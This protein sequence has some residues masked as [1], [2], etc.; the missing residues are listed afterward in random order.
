MFV[1]I[2]F[3]IFLGMVVACYFCVHSKWRAGVLLAASYLFCGFISLRALF[4][5]LIISAVTYLAGREIEK[6]GSRDK[7]GMGKVLL[8]LTIGS[9]LLL[10]GAYKYISYGFLRL[11]ILERMPES[12]LAQLVMPV[13]LSFYLFQAIGYLTDIYRKKHKAEKNFIYL[14]LYLAFFAKFVSGPIE[15]EEDFIP[16]LKGLEKVRFFHRGRL[17]TAF[18][19]MLWGYFMKMVVADRLAVTADKIFEAPEKFDSFWLLLG[20][21]F[22]TIQ[23]YCD[24]AGYS[25]IAIGCA[26]IFGINLTQNFNMP[27]CA[28][29]ITDFWRRWH[30]SLSFWLRDYLYIP[31]GGNRKG[32]FRKGIN[33]MIVFIAC[34]MWHGSGLNF[35][36]WGMLHGLYSVADYLWG[37]K[38][39][40]RL[41]TF[42]EVAVAWIF[43]RATGL[44]SALTYVWKMLTSGFHPEQ[45]VSVMEQM[46]LSGVEMGISLFGIM[47][48]G[49]ADQICYKKNKHL[50]DL[51]QCGENAV[52]YVIFYL[53]LIIIFVF[54]MYGPGYH[55]EDFIY[56]QF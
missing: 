12:L 51:I 48:I 55:A 1:S 52:R 13:G 7:R 30:I 28:K 49:A 37:K 43:F 19:Y 31:L 44:R 5:L 27:Y 38:K 32:V 36:A 24:F 6:A 14:G 15:R 35:I 22:Y 10:M 3:L 20:A 9:Y 33:T 2:Y 47:I 50:P 26:R 34:G 45:F 41:I 21:L 18:T 46:K 17:S 39:G 25:Y 8:I 54:G 56:M 23:I 42:L 4:V 11:G 53:L 16:Q 40:S 29:S